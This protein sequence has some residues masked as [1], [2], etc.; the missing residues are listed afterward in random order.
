MVPWM[1][2]TKRS[3]M[4]QE[5]LRRYEDTQIRLAMLRRGEEKSATLIQVQYASSVIR[6]SSRVGGRRWRGG[7]E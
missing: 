6:K 4:K 5:A 3:A 1:K 7:N 2:A